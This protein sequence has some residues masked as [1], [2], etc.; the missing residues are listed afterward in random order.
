LALCYLKGKGVLSDKDKAL[1]W[2]KKA[3]EQGYV[4]SKIYIKKLEAGK[5][6]YYL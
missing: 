3:D 4:Q 6:Y 1:E 2:F 5:Y